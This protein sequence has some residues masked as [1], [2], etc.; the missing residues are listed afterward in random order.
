MEMTLN[1]AKGIK[2][3]EISLCADNVMKISCVLTVSIQTNMT[4]VI[5]IINA[6][7]WITSKENQAFNCIFYLKLHIYLSVLSLL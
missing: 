7:I 2:L 1:D 3:L 4:L 6:S 5:F